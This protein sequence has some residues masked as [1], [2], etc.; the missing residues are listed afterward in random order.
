[1]K[2]WLG[3]VRGSEK[4]VAANWLPFDTI[5]EI[6]GVEYRVADRMNRKYGYPFMDAK[7]DSKTEAFRL[8]RQRQTIVIHSELD[9]HLSVK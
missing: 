3:A 5:V 7:V 8:G 2:T 6:D 9:N 1:M 4:I